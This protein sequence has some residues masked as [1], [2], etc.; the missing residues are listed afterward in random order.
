MG[1]YR[2]VKRGC[3]DAEDTKIYFNLMTGQKVFTSTADVF[4]IE[5]PNTSSQFLRYVAFH[6]SFASLPT[7][8]TGGVAGTDPRVM[9]APA[10][11]FRLKSDSPAARYGAYA[12]R[13]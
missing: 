8:E 11:D 2:V 10:G 12:R 7:A 13:A 9:D 4:Q 1:F 6:S 5:V 3:C